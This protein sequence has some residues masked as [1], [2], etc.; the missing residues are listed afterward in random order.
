[1]YTIKKFW[2]DPYLT[3]LQTKIKTIDNNII[4]LEETIVYAFSGGQASD[5]GKINDYPI[6][7]A[8]K[9]DKEIYYTISENHS[10][11][12]GDIVSVTIDWEKRYK[13][14]KLHFAA[15]LILELVYQNFN[16][17]TKIGANI[18]SEKARIDFLWDNNINEIF[19]LL[20]EKFDELVDANHSITSAFSSIEDER[21]YWE[22]PSFAKVSCG[23][24]HIRNTGEIGKIRLKRNRQGLGKERIEIYLA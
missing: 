13:I 20:Y 14:M 22:I 15:E 23:G 9:A 12:V 3:E 4:T 1:M 6:L 8:Q 10:L 24:T 17:P 5:E 21:R 7:L 11:K 16:H 19:P 2:E 18:T